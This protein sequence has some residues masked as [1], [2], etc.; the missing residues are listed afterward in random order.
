[1]RQMIELARARKE[2]GQ[3]AGMGREGGRKHIHN[4]RRIKGGE[5]EWTG[6]WGEGGIRD[7]GGIIASL[8][9][10]KR[11]SMTGT[12]IIYHHHLTA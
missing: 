1:M 3:E 2:E 12:G 5:E 11:K 10:D 8:I 4:M 6:C 9:R 7:S